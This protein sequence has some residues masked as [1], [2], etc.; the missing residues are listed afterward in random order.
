MRDRRRRL[1]RIASFALMTAVAATSFAA[2]CAATDSRNAFEVYRI[3]GDELTA[4]AFAAAGAVFVVVWNLVL[5]RAAVAGTAQI[6]QVNALNQQILDSSCDGIAAVDTD[7]NFIL[8]NG[9]AVRL[10]GWENGSVVGVNISDTHLASLA[11]RTS[12]RQV[13]SGGASGTRC[14]MDLDVG[15]GQRIFNVS[16]APLMPAKSAWCGY[17]AASKCSGALLVFSDVTALRRSEQIESTSFVM[18]ALARSVSSVAAEVRNPLLS[19]REYLEELPVRHGDGEFIDEICRFVPSQIDRVEAVI[20]DLL[21]FGRP[22]PPRREVFDLAECV[23]EALNRIEAEADSRGI[24]VHSQIEQ[25]Q[26]FADRAQIADAVFRVIE[27][28]VA[29]SKYMSEVEV[30]LRAASHDWAEVEVRDCASCSGFERAGSER[31]DSAAELFFRAGPGD[32]ALGMAVSYRILQQN[33]GLLT[34]STT[35]NGTCIEMRIPRGSPQAT[36]ARQSL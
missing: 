14:D 16:L 23:S 20:A 21:V 22:E 34:A 15:S 12:L 7:L 30:H 27:S 32:P 6:A 8:A 24:I 4:I 9:A 10:M 5:R 31:S 33:G 26:V 13:V 3:G 1:L 28:A 29:S 17:V 19:I 2:S 35:P 36:T 18:S 11:Y 25:T